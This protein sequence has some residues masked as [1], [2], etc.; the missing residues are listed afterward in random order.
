MQPFPPIEITWSYNPSQLR[1]QR[2]CIRTNLFQSH[3]SGFTIHHPHVRLVM[4]RLFGLNHGLPLSIF[5]RED[6]FVILTG[7]LVAGPGGRAIWEETWSARILHNELFLSSKRT[8]R[9][10]ADHE[11]E[12][13][14]R[15]ELDTRAYAICGHVNM[16]LLNWVGKEEYMYTFAALHPKTKPVMECKDVV[17]EC[18]QC[19]TDYDTTIESRWVVERWRSLVYIASIPSPIV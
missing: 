4:N 8:V 12:E 17:G 3:E 13:K 14:L 18:A 15:S 19:F 2:K 7:L 6:L 10:G 11:T 16:Q 9:W 1:S 5:N